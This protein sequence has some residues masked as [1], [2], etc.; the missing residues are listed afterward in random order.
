M[1]ESRRLKLVISYDGR[2]F[3]GWQS[4]KHQN[5]VQDQL[6][7][8]FQRVCGTRVAVI[9]SGRTDSGVHALGQC[10][11]V[12]VPASRLDAERWL[13][14]MN[15]VLPSA[16]RVLR[17]RF[18]AKTF[19]ARFSATGKVYR[20]RI[21]N[22]AVRP[23]LEI[24]RAWH[25][26][27]PLDRELLEQAAKVFVGRHDFAAFAANRG[28]EERSTTRT[29]EYVRVSARRN[30]I[31]IEFCADGFLYKMARLIVG[32]IVGCARRK[33]SL[34]SLQ[35]RLQRPSRSSLRFTAPAA[36]LYLVRVRYLIRS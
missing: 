17:A 16:I 12:D 35:L 3:A 34:S 10:A 20:Y 31:E 9:G 1:P 32:A 4:Q 5:T 36:G 6:E 13:K 27:A 11:H 30:Q 15:G 8:A 7:S 2:D 26:A 22:G 14:A 28:K 21:I 33:E 25:V 24:G 29:L 19:H 23:P 18:V